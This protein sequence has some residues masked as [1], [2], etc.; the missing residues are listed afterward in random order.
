ML[1]SDQSSFERIPPL[2]GAVVPTAWGDFAV[3]AAGFLEVWGEA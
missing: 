2:E 1:K 3:L